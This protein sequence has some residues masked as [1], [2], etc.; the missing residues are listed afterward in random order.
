MWGVRGSR[1]QLTIYNAVQKFRHIS[2]L[3]L[4]FMCLGK[5]RPEVQLR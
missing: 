1:V 3:I 2:D 5:S 4:L